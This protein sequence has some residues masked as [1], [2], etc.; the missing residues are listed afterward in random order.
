M[1]AL[2]CKCITIYFSITVSPEGSVKVSP[3][4]ITAQFDTTITAGCTA[5]GGPDNQFTWS[6]VT[7]FGESSV[8][9][10]GPVLVIN[11][12][13]IESGIYACHVEN[14]AGY[15]LAYLKIYGEQCS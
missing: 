8:V 4:V 13:D 2:L 9:Q 7:G 6:V 5:E 12:T 3:S 10:Y 11:V 15:E 14:A 1:V